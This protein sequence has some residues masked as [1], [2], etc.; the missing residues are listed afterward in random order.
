MARREKQNQSSGK[1]KDA[2][3]IKPLKLNKQTA[4]DPTAEE[5]NK[6]KGGALRS[7]IQDDPFFFDGGIS[8]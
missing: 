4:Q 7:A 3:K 6:V 2:G 5:L 8:K 1:Q